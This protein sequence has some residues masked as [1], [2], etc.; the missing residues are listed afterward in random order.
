MDEMKLKAQTGLF[1]MMI[2]GLIKKFVKKKT[3]LD[4]ELQI[5]ELEMGTLPNKKVRVNATIQLEADYEDVIK[6]I[7]EKK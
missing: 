6:L 1:K 2:A 3:D 4:M 7:G 5:D